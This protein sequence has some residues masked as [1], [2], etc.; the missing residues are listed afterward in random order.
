MK[1]VVFLSVL[2]MV[3]GLISLVFA[4][5]PPAVNV[6]NAY[7]TLLTELD[8]NRDGKLSMAECMGMY[9]DKNIGK[10]KCEFWDLNKDGTITE[11]EYAQQ[12]MNI[13][14]RKR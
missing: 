5:G 4:A 13:G 12:V 10:Q 2:F 1:K 9:K 6:K 8:K 7:K 3:I 14:K 11:E